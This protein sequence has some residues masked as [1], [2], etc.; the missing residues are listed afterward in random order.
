VL[1][2]AEPVRDIPALDAASNKSKFVIALTTHAT[3]NHKE[4]ADLLLP[5]GSFAETS[6]T[7]INCEGRW[8][9]F[10]GVSNPVGESRPAWK[11]LRAIGSLLEFKAF[12]YDSS[13][14]IL[15]E[16]TAKLQN[17]TSTNG[18]AKYSIQMELGKQ[19][20]LG[21]QSTKAT[22]MYETDMVLRHATSLQL[23]PE[24]ARSSLK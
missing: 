15:E 13:E 9:S 17:I 21:E 1:L 4:V 24:A 8:Q 3:E 10:S 12:E 6:G 2:N 20:V 19:D 16:V 22:P 11:V 7:Y 14:S 23:T 5:I 18:V